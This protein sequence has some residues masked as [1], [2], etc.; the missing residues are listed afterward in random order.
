MICTP[1]LSFIVFSLFNYTY[2]VRNGTEFKTKDNLF[3]F[4]TNL[5]FAIIINYACTI[6][7]VTLA[8]ILAILP[9]L[10]LMTPDKLKANNTATTSATIRSTTVIKD[11]KKESFGWGRPLS[12]MDYGA[13]PYSYY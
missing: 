8:W 2:Y 6:N 13:T 1:A 11:K 5:I 3:L 7:Y 9:L 4:I 12:T 10:D